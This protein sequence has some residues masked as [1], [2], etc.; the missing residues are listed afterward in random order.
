M[1][2]FARGG[3]AGMRGILLKRAPHDAGSTRYIARARPPSGTP[4]LSIVPHLPRNRGSG[5]PATARA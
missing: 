5:A 3:A 4:R 1:P 2:T